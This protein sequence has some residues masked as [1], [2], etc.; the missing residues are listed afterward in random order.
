MAKPKGTTYT[1]VEAALIALGGNLSAVARH[2]G[3]TRQSLLSWL[4]RYPKLA[5]IAQDE[6]DKT[7]DVA[8]GHL[9]TLILAGDL[10]ACEYWLE[11]KRPDTWRRVR[12]HRA[13]QK[14]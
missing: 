5:E 12:T 9:I 1:A 6:A 11:A 3:I 7:S 2:L 13:S 4:R 14:H 10:D 8:E